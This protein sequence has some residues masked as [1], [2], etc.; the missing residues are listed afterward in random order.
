VRARHEDAAR[1][2][3]DAH[4]ALLALGAL[5]YP[6][7]DDEPAALE[8]EVERRR[9]AADEVLGLRGRL[10]RRPLAERELD[11]ARALV[12]DAGGRLETLREKVKSLAF[13][14]EA[15]AAARARRDEA[16]A[17][18]DAANAQAAAT[19]LARERAVADVTAAQT[20]LA[21]ATEQHEKLAAIGEDARHLGRLADLLHGFRN[22]QVATVGPRLSMQAAELFGE[23]TDNE[24]DRLEV[25]PE[26]YGIQIRDAGRLYDMERF[27]GSETD[28]ANL[29]LRVAISEHVRFQTGGQVGLLVLDEVF[30]PLD[31]DRKDRM[32]R[33]LERLKGR[34]RQVLVVTHDS[35][36]KE[37]L[38]HAIEVVKLPG[39]RAQARLVAG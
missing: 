39:R 25:D 4:A 8:T 32:L 5:A 23:L 24:Y 22:A 18:L 33:A 35:E 27:S 30:G 1:A 7:R 34:F 20:R 2:A 36:V 16:K 15:L 28:L 14:G 12:A 11:A 38:P 10:E 17:A 21:D 9:R 26:T 19:A 37:Q 29:A 6:L 31:P 3:A 13:D